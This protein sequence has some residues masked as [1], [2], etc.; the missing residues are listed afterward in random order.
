MV[1][2]EVDMIKAAV[3]HRRRVAVAVV[4]DGEENV[5]STATAGGETPGGE[6]PSASVFGRTVF[7]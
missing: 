5:G 3:I 6:K 7:T 2:E 4:G 1:E